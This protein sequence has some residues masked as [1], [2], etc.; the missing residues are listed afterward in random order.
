MIECGSHKAAGDIRA[1]AR[2]VALLC[3]VAHAVLVSATHY[4]IAPHLAKKGSSAA[5]ESRRES[6][7]NRPHGSD[8]HN[9]CLSC[10]L[11]R[12]FVSGIHSSAVILD[13]L[14]GP[15]ERETFVL[16]SH[17]CEPFFISPSRAPPLV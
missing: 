4:H 9:H 7:Q 2:A 8:N 15:V 10:R 14:S 16:Q 3:L 5:L 17:S 12:N 6:D 1:L 11:H 13:L